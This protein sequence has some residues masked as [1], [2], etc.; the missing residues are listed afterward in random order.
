MD[1]L[2]MN[3]DLKARLNELE[4]KSLLSLIPGIKRGLEKESLRVDSKGLL[5]QTP[6][7]KELGSSLTHPMITTDF[8]EALLEFITPPF[9]SIDELFQS[10]FE[11]HEFTYWVLKRQ[12][13]GEYLWTGS[14]PCMLPVE[15][16]IPIAQF[17][18]SNLGQLRY[19]YRKGL[20][21]RYGRTMQ[22]IAGIHYNFSLSDAFWRKYFEIHHNKNSKNQ[23]LADFISEE[24]LGMIRNGL[25]FGWILPFLFGASP[26]ICK[27]FVK[28]KA[29][30]NLEPLSKHSF[31]GPF[32][33]SL[34]LSDLGYHN[35]NLT[36]DIISYNS[37]NEFL[38]TM[39]KAVHTIEPE[40]ARFGVLVNG[41]YRQ[42]SACRLQIEDEHYASF[43]PKRVSQPEERMW[44]ALKRSGIEYIEVRS[45]DL[46][47]FLPLGISK[48]TIYFMDIFLIMCLLLESPMITQKEH[49]EINQ[50][51]AK[52]VTLG[53]K[54]NLTLINPKG[55]E[56]LL[57]DWIKE[58]WEN[59][60]SV[61]N[62]LDKAFETKKYT[63]VL[64]LFSKNWQNMDMLPSAQIVSELKNTG[65]S[66]FQFMERRAIMHQNF[67]NDLE[68]KK[69][70]LDKFIKM[71]HDSI[72][73]QQEKEESH[74]PS[75][76]EFLKEY[77]SA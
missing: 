6:H 38:A 68:P 29:G 2:K 24:Y 45:F 61:A 17:G 8:S 46:N 70:L 50:N 21:L 32:A 3:M 51:Q 41:E 13:Q 15:A 57:L 53:R 77:L 26:A 75:F 72:R 27:G 73:A 7:P 71:A 49:N 66:Y 44:L 23:N 52:V 9:E 64:S 30:Q 54:P 62:M 60:E 5:A 25:R 63:E 12:N 76:G 58:I 16:Q 39:H 18:S 36:Q 20:G 10:L 22:T 40:F 14:M 33:T 74:S 19:V 47:P 59:L 4:K 37:F 43:R 48:E 31:Y 56:C 35:K 42:L 55:E 65:E 34:R 1:N 69:P 67:F 28:G 11:I